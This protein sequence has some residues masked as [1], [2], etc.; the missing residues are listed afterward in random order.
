[1]NALLKQYHTEYILRQTHKNVSSYTKDAK[2]LEN[3]YVD[4]L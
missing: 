2:K 1:M 3:A 4:R